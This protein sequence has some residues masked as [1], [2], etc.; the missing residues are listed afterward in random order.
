MS[1]QGE[2]GRRARCTDAIEP[3]RKDQRVGLQS[4]P[5]GFLRSRAGHKEKALALKSTQLPR[6]HRTSN[7]SNTRFIARSG[8]DQIACSSLLLPL[9]IASRPYPSPA[10]HAR[11]E[12]H[13]TSPIYITPLTRAI[14]DLSPESVRTRLCALHRFCRFSLYRV[15]TPRLPPMLASKT[16][17]LPPLPG[18]AVV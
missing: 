14:R 6:I 4:G 9:S 16:Y 11:P 18:H 1:F 5:Y 10:S 7:K 13:P 12:I 8:T 3:G 2:H 17:Q 15:R